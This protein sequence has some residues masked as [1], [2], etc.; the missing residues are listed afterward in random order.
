MLKGGK[1]NGGVKKGKKKGRCWEI[2]VWKKGRVEGGEKKGG[3]GFTAKHMQAGD[4]P[5]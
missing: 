4:M 1:R 3:G 5:I 2:L